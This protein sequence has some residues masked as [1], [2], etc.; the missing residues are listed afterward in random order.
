MLVLFGPVAVRRGEP[1]DTPRRASQ[2]ITAADQWRSFQSGV[3]ADHG[4]PI[5]LDDFA[6]WAKVNLASDADSAS[7]RP[8]AVLAPTGPQ[9]D[10]ADAWS[11]CLP[12]DPARLRDPTLIVR[13]E[14][15]SVTR[16]GDAAWLV[17][18]L[19]NVPGGA[20]DVR[21]PR[22]A[23]RMHLETNRRALFDAVGTFLGEPA[24]QP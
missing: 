5:E 6:A 15:D 10:I 8:P 3:P 16:D 11:G 17:R 24:G 22:G 7:R 12:Y 20:R 23:H 13:G 21:L 4:S 1:S 2:L 9:A 18:A 14:W 19:A